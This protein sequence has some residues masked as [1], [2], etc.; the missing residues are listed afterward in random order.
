MIFPLL[1]IDMYIPLNTHSLAVRLAMWQAWEERAESFK[2]Q[3]NGG[4]AL[5]LLKHNDTST[6]LATLYL[7]HGVR[8]AQAAAVP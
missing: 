2:E 7:H 4:W 5:S 1:Y 8:T 6:T 3:M